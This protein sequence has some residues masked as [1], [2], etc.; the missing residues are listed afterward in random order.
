MPDKE[1]TQGYCVGCGKYTTG[2][3]VEAINQWSD[4]VRGYECYPVPAETPSGV[5]VVR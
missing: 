3:Y 5:Q 2:E 4:S 1:M